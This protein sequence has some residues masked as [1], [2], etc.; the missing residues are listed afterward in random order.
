MNSRVE[1]PKTRFTR[2]ELN[3]S[4]AVCLAPQ[5]RGKGI[6]HVVVYVLLRAMKWPMA[7]HGKPGVCLEHT[8]HVDTLTDDRFDFFCENTLLNE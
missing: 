1:C 2:I 6:R 3:D 8:L 7:L 5:L 4:C